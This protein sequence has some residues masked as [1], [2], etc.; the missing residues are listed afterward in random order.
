MKHF[1]RPLLWVG[2]LFALAFPL[3]A[4]QIYSNGPIITGTGNGG[5]GANSSAISTGLTV[6]GFAV[7][8]PFSMA[9]D[10][11]VPAGERWNLTSAHFFGYQTGS[12]TTPS[13]NQL[14]IQ[15]WDGMPGTVGASVIWGNLTTNRLNTATFSNIYRVFDVVTD[16]QRP[17]MDLKSSSIA[18][19]LNPGTYWIEYAITGSASFSGPWGVPVVTG[20]SVTGNGR[21][22]N[23]GW[24]DLLDGTFQQG[25]AFTLDGSVSP[26]GTGNPN[27]PPIANFDHQSGVDTVWINSPHT[28]VNTSAN[29]A[30]SSWR[31]SYLGPA[32]ICRPGRGCFHDTTNYNFHTQFNQRGYYNVTLVVGNN[33]GWDS[34]T[35]IVF[36]DTPTSKPVVD[37]Y[38][39]KVAM[40][41][42]DQSR[43][44]DVSRN[45]PTG[46]K[47]TLS[48]E[49]Y[50]CADTSQ[51]FNMFTKGTGQLG[52]D[53]AQ[54]L[55]IPNEPGDYDVCLKVWNA[56]GAD[57]LCRSKHLSIR[58]GVN[59]CDGIF[60]DDHA[61][62]YL[63]DKGG[64][65]NNYQAATLNCTGGFLINPCAT[66]LV[67]NIDFFRLRNND[68]LTIRD[69]GP[70][71]NILADLSGTT[72]PNRRIEVPSGRAY[73][74]MTTGTTTPTN[75]GDSGFI[76]RWTSIPATYGPPTASFSGADSIYSGYTAPYINTTK[77]FGDI[78]YEWDI[79]NDGIYDATTKDISLMFTSTSLV[80]KTVRLRA[81]NCR[82]SAEFIKTIVVL[83]IVAVPLVD[84]EAAYTEGFA[85]DAF[86]LTDKSRNG[87]NQ[88]TWRFSPGDVTYLSGTT[89]NSQN[90][91]VRLG[92][93][94]RYTVTLIAQNS[95]GKDS[96]VKT[97]YLYV[98]SHSSPYTEFILSGTSDVG[99]TRVQFADV[100]FF[101]PLNNPIFQ[102]FHETQIATVYRGVKYT[103][104]AT[105]LTATSPMTRM[106]WVDKNVDGDF[107]D[108]GEIIAG[109]VNTQTL[110]LQGD[111]KIPNDIEPGR[112]T[113]LR[114][115]VSAG[116]SDLTPEKAKAGCFEDYGV[117]IGN[118]LVKPILT[119][120]GS[121]LHRVELNK[122]YV[123]PGVIAIDNREGD[124]S[125]KVQVFG[126][127]NI[128]QV[129]YYTLKYIATDLY[130]NVSD[131]LRRTVQVEINQTGP[132]ITLTG[133]DTMYIE[134]FDPFNDPGVV[135][136]DNHG[137]EITPLMVK[138]GHVDTSHIGKYI[139]TYS[140]TDAFG[141]T[142]SKNRVIFIRDTKA[143]VITTSY[144]GPLIKHQV[145]T[146]FKD[147]QIIVSDN[148]YNFEQLT[149]VR[150]G[151]I[152]V[153]VP[154]QYSLR[155]TASDPSNN[156]SAEYM[157]WV[158]VRDT[159]HPVATLKG[160]NPLL[161]DVYKPL[162]DPG[163]AATD[164]FYN[165]VIV[166]SNNNV[167]INKLGQYKITYIVRDPAGNETS[168]YRDVL[169]VDREPP[170]IELE[171]SSVVEMPRWA[172]YEEIGL[173]LKDNYNT[174]EELAANVHIKTNLD[175]KSDGKYFA[176][177]GGWKYITYIVQD[178][179]G[180]VSKPVT[181]YIFADEALAPTGINEYGASGNLSVYPNPA[182]DV[183]YLK[184][185]EDANTPVE[186]KVYN[187]LGDEVMSI[188]RNALYAAEELSLNTSTWKE[189]IYLVNIKYGGKQ[190]T[191]RVVITR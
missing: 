170:R 68:K 94:G 81:T 97:N 79:N 24:V 56:R 52:N 16:V 150:E 88:W 182:K 110:T 51:L 129:G 141:F 43:A 46:W 85:S 133:P 66:D 171:G 158:D 143:P 120:I 62:G 8:P 22:F 173:K 26:I 50:N 49:C 151:S 127:V 18:M 76:I 31:S 41:I 77:G 146:P 53:T 108:A 140:V 155:Y 185:K 130:G 34:V 135:A 137:N 59:M 40:G 103:A 98:R 95:A 132:T 36:V 64:P 112:L 111:F 6:Y 165:N 39:D 119:L 14:F 175:L 106:I 30:T 148:Y 115:G 134:V 92:S 60:T 28:F 188:K 145:G 70:T 142:V 90:P 116:Y 67:L 102:D 5:G 157:V 178:A 11:V 100:D 55:F 3:S 19:T 190:A 156:T 154:E 147:L 47:W 20:A 72:V 2:A 167:N 63:F 45:G 118:D 15:I 93:V 54:P 126:Q 37:F 122:P 61:E 42:S 113:R 176:N 161:A 75:T 84:F 91:I 152:N 144:G 32:T 184:L 65:L 128:S 109:E 10:F 164:N 189:G 105:R 80:M 123:E 33:V 83:P 71:G 168:I 57:S 35:K 159:I 44:H 99:I 9:D 186:I 107:Y 162:Q 12:G 117:L 191:Q 180:N 124:I 38:F 172:D 7:S 160:T 29:A 1:V 139:I 169:V 125:S 187:V 13:I 17:I 179:A 177:L 25:V 104:I 121:S 163:V 48:P 101:S 86:R 114:V 58:H 23:A 87:P 149:I 131:T 73:L 181:R 82:G 4:Q 174:P 96:L 74:F 78:T 69:G 136:R 138:E 21:Q 183:L 153:N 89:E 27:L 166:I